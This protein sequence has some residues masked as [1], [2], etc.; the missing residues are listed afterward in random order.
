MH[1][2]A[3]LQ[4]YCVCS[5]PRLGRI[6]FQK[7]LLLQTEIA[8]AGFAYRGS[9]LE[10]EN[11]GPISNDGQTFSQFHR[12]CKSRPLRPPISGHWPGIL[13]SFPTFP[14]FHR[15]Y[16][17]RPLRPRFS[18]YCS[19]KKFFSDF[20]E[21]PSLVRISPTAPTIFELLLTEKVFFPTFPKFH[22][23]YESRPLRPRFSDYCCGKSVF[24]PSINNNYHGCAFFLS[25]V[26]LYEHVSFFLFSFS[27]FSCFQWAQW[28]SY[29]SSYSSF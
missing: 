3:C 26:C 5:G 10:A 23:W 19:R 13:L 1:L 8:K 11:F 6:R 12:W 25:D 16:E 7:R 27:L 18:D 21:I 15:W 17:S 2:R 24:F 22:R 28:A 4:Q 20:S 14:K 9:F 29:V